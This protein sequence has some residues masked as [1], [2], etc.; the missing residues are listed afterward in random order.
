[1]SKEYSTESKSI[2]SDIKDLILDCRIQNKKCFVSSQN[3]IKLRSFRNDMLALCSPSTSANH[4]LSSPENKKSSK[5]NFKRNP[6]SKR[7]SKCLYDAKMLVKELRSNTETFGCNTSSDRFDF[8]RKLTIKKQI[9]DCN[10][11]LRLQKMALNEEFALTCQ[12][13]ID[14][15]GQTYASGSQRTSPF[16]FS[17]SRGATTLS[18]RTIPTTISRNKSIFSSSSSNS[19]GPKLDFIKNQFWNKSLKNSLNQN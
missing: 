14:S 7:R 16:T 10:K 15:F 18:A 19:I 12:N 3:Q 1:M 6:P 4:P 5:L 13:T 17:E 11:N 2:K 9:N 8:S